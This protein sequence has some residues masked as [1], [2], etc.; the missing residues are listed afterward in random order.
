MLVTLGFQP[1]LKISDYLP[2][3]VLEYRLT[4]DLYVNTL[5]TKLKY[6]YFLMAKVIIVRSYV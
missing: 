2:F 1:G 4:Q 3:K 6:Y 5:F